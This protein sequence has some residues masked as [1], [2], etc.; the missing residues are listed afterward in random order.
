[1]EPQDIARM[2]PDPDDLIARY[3]LYRNHLI[4]KVASWNNR[5][6]IGRAV[7]P[8]EL[9]RIPRYCMELEEMVSISKTNPQ[10][11]GAVY[12]VDIDPNSLVEMPFEWHGIG[13]LDQYY[14]P[15]I[16]EMHIIIDH[17]KE[18]FNTRSEE[19]CKNLLDE[20]GVHVDTSII[21]ANLCWLIKPGIKKTDKKAGDYKTEVLVNIECSMRL[22]FTE[23]EFDMVV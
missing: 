6:P 7:D 10:Y 1:M 15:N 3:E 20:L 22:L 11:E 19:E 21:V 13:F 14:T 9:T 8:T 23:Q 18:I 12:L 17:K 16:P 5:L 2:I 4:K